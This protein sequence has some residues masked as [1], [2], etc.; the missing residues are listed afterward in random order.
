MIAI[1]TKYGTTDAFEAGDDMLKAMLEAQSNLGSPITWAH[2]SEDV[3]R[4]VFTGSEGKLRVVV[5]D[6]MVTSAREALELASWVNGMIA[7]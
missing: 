7:D 2:L 1:V 5:A 6:L 3:A 4:G